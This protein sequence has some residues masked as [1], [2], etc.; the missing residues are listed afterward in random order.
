MSIRLKI[1]LALVVTGVVPALSF[2]WFAETVVYKSRVAEVHDKLQVFA[3]LQ[4]QRMTESFQHDSEKVALIASRTQ[5]RKSLASYLHE[6]Q[7]N[8]ID[9]IETIIRDA[10]DS[11]PYFKTISLATMDRKII[12]STHTGSRGTSL[13]A[14]NALRAALTGSYGFTYQITP[15]HG[16][17]PDELIHQVL[18]GPVIHQGKQIGIIIVKTSIKETINR[19]D[20]E[21]GFG[22]QGRTRLVR[23]DK[24]QIMQCL[25]PLRPKDKAIGL[26]QKSGKPLTKLPRQNGQ[27][28][29]TDADDRQLH[30]VAIA[31]VEHTN[32]AVITDIN[33][34]VA[35]EPIDNLVTF[36]RAVGILSIISIFVVSVFFARA[37]SRPLRRVAQTAKRISTG[38]LD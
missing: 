19:I 15:E 36:G 16:E 35:L 23:T 9:R 7:T 20:E 30:V 34:E 5:M 26:L 11:V 13:N 38:D 33:K 2:W 32:L 10:R 21:A 29:L 17:S 4:A 8:K 24:G 12:A 28:V 3:D 25:V 1:L 22:G 31:P 18:C 14:S 27:H 37:L 6:P